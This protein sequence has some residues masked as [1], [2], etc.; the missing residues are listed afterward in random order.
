MRRAVVFACVAIAGAAHHAAAQE[1]RPGRIDVSAGLMWMGGQTLGSADATETTPTQTAFTLF[2]STADLGAGAGIEGRVGVRVS[3]AIDAQISGSYAKPTVKVSVANDV[4]GA[5]PLTA[6]DRLDQYTIS[7]GLV[8]YP[9]A[10]RAATSRVAPFVSGDVGYLRQLHESATLVQTG[11][12]V[13][14]G[15]GV[16]YAWRS[17]AGRLKSSGLRFDA[18]AALR[19]KGAAFDDAIHA[20]PTVVVSFF[21]RF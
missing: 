18:G 19:S 7:F 4:E 5:A 16:T 10:R 14:V 9:A 17:G 20:A 11:R 3:R 1:P 6:E 13:R 8:W 21:A 2:S 15:G 12:I